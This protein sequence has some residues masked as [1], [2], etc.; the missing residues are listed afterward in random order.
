MYRLEVV[1]G[2]GWRGA[3]WLV[4]IVLPGEGELPESYEVLRKKRTKAEARAEADK[5]RNDLVS[6]SSVLV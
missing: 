4:A 3:N 2:S 6:G 5:I 1:Q